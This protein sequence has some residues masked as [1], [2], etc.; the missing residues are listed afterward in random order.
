MKQVY[1]MDFRHLTCK[2][3]HSVYFKIIHNQG[4]YDRELKNISCYQGI[5]NVLADIA[6]NR[7]AIQIISDKIT[8]IEGVLSSGK[9]LRKVLPDQRILKPNVK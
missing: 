3:I 8:E 1:R 2:D 5:S 6:E 9:I 4:L 7:K